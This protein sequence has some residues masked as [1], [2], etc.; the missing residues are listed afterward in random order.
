MKKL[1]AL[2]LCLMMMAFAGAAMA[3]SAAEQAFDGTWVQFEDGFE[4]YLPSEWLEI[5]TTDEMLEAG[6]F[7]AV[8]SPDGAYTCQLA[9]SGLDDEMTLE[10]VQ[11]ELATIYPDA[12]II[13][14]ENVEMVFYTDTE[15]DVMGCAALD[16]AEPGLYQFYFTPASDEDF[17]LLAA[18]IATSI[19]NIAE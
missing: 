14:T 2:V 10:E 19:R 1:L 13:A 18:Y 9:W 15:N 12:E 11:A 6:I 8:C 3:E 16:A 17:T 5:E 4:L 7:Y